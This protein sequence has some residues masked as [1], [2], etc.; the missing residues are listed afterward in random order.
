[1]TQAALE[2]ER[3]I[4]AGFTGGA[5]REDIDRALHRLR[6]HRDVTAASIEKVKLGLDAAAVVVP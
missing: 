6:Q 2:E 3:L 5:E 4:E 1:V